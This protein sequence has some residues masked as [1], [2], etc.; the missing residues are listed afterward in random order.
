MLTLIKKRI[1]YFFKPV[2]DENEIHFI[3]LRQNKKSFSNSKNNILV[4]A[5]AD[6]IYVRIIEALINK[7]PNNNFIGVYTSKFILKKEDFLFFPFLYRYIVYKKEK[8]YFFKQ[9]W[10]AHKAN[11][12]IYSI[13]IN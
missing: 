7:F 1:K 2:L 5:T 12:E 8:S 3:N 6:L 4:E 13:F 10:R 9:R 11:Q